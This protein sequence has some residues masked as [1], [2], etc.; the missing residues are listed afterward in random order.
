MNNDR[1]IQDRNLRQA[2]REV[3]AIFQRRRLAGACMIV[4]P[5]EAAFTYAMHA[6][7]SALRPDSTTPLGFR[8]RAHSA[9]DGK[10][11]TE[12]RVEGAMHT[13]CQLSDFGAQTMDWME[14]LKAM[15]RHAGIDFDHTPFNGKPPPPLEPWDGRT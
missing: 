6:P 7:W 14:Q 2:L 8:F 5:D 15:L 1:P 13:I 11:L 9:E 12:E 3:Q 4:A 10:E